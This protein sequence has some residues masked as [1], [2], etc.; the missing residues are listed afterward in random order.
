M[1]V[2]QW[3]RRG[4]SF[5]KNTFG[6]ST[7]A[8]RGLAAC[9][10]VLAAGGLVLFRAPHGVGAAPS[11]PRI[12]PPVL[13]E[14]ELPKL[15]V[16]TPTGSNSA[17]FSGPGAHGSIALSHSKALADARQTLYGEL[18]VRADKE[19]RKGVHAP[20][21][22]AVV[23]D[24]S[25]S[26]SGD[27]IEQAKESVIKLIRQMDDADEL[28]VVRYSDEAST[29]VPLGRVSEVRATAIARVKNLDADG[30]TAIPRGLSLGLSQVGSRS[31]ERVRR[32]I[33]V[34]DGLDSTRAQAERLAANSFERGIVVSSLGIG[35]DFDEGYM[36]SVASRGHGNFGFVKDAP[37]LATFLKR[38]L[39]ET[40]KTVV[41]NATVRVT[42][43]QGV[44]FQRASG[45]D[46]R[47]LGHGEIELKLGSLFAGDERRVV[48]EMESNGAEASDAMKFLTHAAWD[49]V[50][51]E[52][53]DVDVAPLTVVATNDPAEVEKG[54]DPTVL[55]SAASVT[56]SRRQMEAAEAYN[57]GDVRKA[58]ALV[59]ES[60][61]HLQAAATAAPAPVAA[62]LAGQVDS[63]AR[64]KK[65]FQSFAP[66]SI[67]AKELSKSVVQDEARNMARKA[68]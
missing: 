4:S 8:R 29:V 6:R 55:A 56:A 44:T 34:S 9:A 47:T 5:A 58:E 15:P 36:S 61:V 25:G 48:L 66:S 49:R 28:A 21:S 42:L 11:I 17:T 20:L 10:V 30:G 3:L 14:T 31:S 53:A 1:P 46:A 37:A 18:L 65:G 39:D 35:L 51:G 27:K 63:Y 24:T 59:D 26:M 16:S 32:I 13:T 12:V 7:R 68:H 54:R 38:E 40:A 67:E 33:L 64:A 22:M 2:P 23:L 41:E 62:A 52:H 50:G 19:D 57:R 45:A 60:I 43:P